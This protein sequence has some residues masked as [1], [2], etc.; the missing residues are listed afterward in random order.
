MSGNE[1]SRRRGMAWESD[2]EPDRSE[3]GERT[4]AAAL[5]LL[6]HRGSG[7]R[8]TMQLEGQ[9]AALTLGSKHRPE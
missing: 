6:N 7:M 4:A 1:N 5:A 3:H 9:S 2:S 8:V